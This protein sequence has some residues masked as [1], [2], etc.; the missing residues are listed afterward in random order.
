MFE[1]GDS[2]KEVKLVKQ[3][4]QNK[5]LSGGE[6]ELSQEDLIPSF[7]DIWDSLDKYDDEYT[8]SSEI[9]KYH[10]SLQKSLYNILFSIK[11]F[12]EL[13][14]DAQFLKLVN[15]YVKF[16]LQ[17]H[18]Q[19][20]E[21]DIS[22][23]ARFHLKNQKDDDEDELVVDE[24]VGVFPT[25][26]P[27]SQ[28]PFE[29]PVTQRQNKDTIECPIAACKKKVYKNSLHPDYEFLHHARYK[30]FRDNIAEAKEYFVNLRNDDSKGFDFVE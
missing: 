4:K 28:M 24:E 12:H 15:R 9:Q 14:I 30:K 5:A 1:Q 27:I 13:N 23:L 19:T 8:P 25:K 17:G 11:Y 3:K 6:D 29:N 20:D 2:S 22:R 26:C 10:N 18:H 7:Q 21:K 16:K